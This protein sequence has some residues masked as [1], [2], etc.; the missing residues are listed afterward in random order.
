MIRLWQRYKKQRRTKMANIEQDLQAIMDARYGRDVRQSIHDAIKDIND[1]EE[2]HVEVIEGY[3]EDAEAWAVG[4]KGGTPV[5]STDPAYHNNAKYYSDNADDSA[6]I[7]EE[8]AKGTKNGTPVTSGE[9]GY[10][11]N[12]KYYAEQASTSESNAEAWA[13]GQRGGSDVEST[14]PTY[15]NNSKYWQERAN[16]WYQQAQAIAESFSGALRPMGTVTFAN[17]PSVSE[18]EA[19]D[20]YNVSDEFTTTSDFVEGAGIVVPLGSNVYLTVGR[21]WDILAGSPVTGVKG[22]S[23]NSYRRGNVNI[24]KANIGLG[25]VDNTSDADKP[26]STAQQ[27]K[28]DEVNTALTSAHNEIDPE[29]ESA[30]MVNA[31]ILPTGSDLNNLGVDGIKCNRIYE[32]SGGASYNNCPVSWGILEVFKPYLDTTDIILERI[33]NDTNIYVR[34]YVQGTGWIA[35]KSVTLA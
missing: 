27:A 9:T 22:S 4:T 12:A 14:D 1:Q 8:Y 11:D 6:E 5:E 26:I 2:G 3:T 33:T 32:L 10:H 35:W 19:G 28:F 23:E 18:A 34:A 29:K 20:M 30:V 15:H 31:G 13:V 17:L 24:T 16:Y 21:K 7:A 25:N